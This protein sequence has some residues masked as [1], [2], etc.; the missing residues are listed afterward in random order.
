MKILMISPRYSN[1]AGDGIYTNSLSLALVKMGIQIS[2]FTI[3]NGMYA[4]LK[5]SKESDSDA[6]SNKPECFTLGKTKNGTLSLNFYSNNA[7]KS[8]RTTLKATKPD[9]IHIHGIHQYFTLSCLF[10]LEQYGAPI[11]I[12][13]HDYKILCGNSGF[14]SDRTN[15]PCIKC[16]DGKLYHPIF[17]KCKKKSLIKSFG[18][19]AQMS[20]WKYFNGLG[21]VN[22]FHA[23]SQ[24]VANILTQN[25]SLK[26]KIKYVRFPFLIQELG[27]KANT[28]ICIAFIGRFVSHKG[29]RIFAEAIKYFNITTHVFGEGSESYIAENLLKTKSSIILHGWKKYSEIY[30]I[31]GKG[32]IVVVPY[33]SYETFCYVIVE[34]MMNGCCVVATNRGAIPELIQNGYNGVLVDPPTPEN[35]RT[36]IEKLLANPERIYSIGHQAKN[37]N[38]TLPSLN[39][40]AHGIVK[41]YSLMVEEQ[42][43]K[44]FKR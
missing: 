31:L 8:L 4:F 7:R 37:I 34:A 27:S 43:N 29:L 19:F 40:H 41:I 44:D 26:N 39:E 5:Y 33:L 2:V 11:M 22:Y 21:S 28:E 24:F 14:F 36:A 20:L 6:K 38:K 9:C 18:V 15:E 25:D 17:E 42:N 30:Q 16:L 32:S 13:A 23:G 35:F 3:I 10:E 1:E 12:T